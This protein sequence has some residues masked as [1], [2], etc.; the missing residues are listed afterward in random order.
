MGGATST[1]FVCLPR[2]PEVEVEAE[3]AEPEVE[4]ADGADDADDADDEADV[5]GA[6]AETSVEPS[7]A[8]DVGADV[9]SAGAGLELLRRLAGRL[10]AGFGAL[11]M[12]RLDLISTFDD[13]LHVRSKPTI[14]VDARRERYTRRVWSFRSLDEWLARIDRGEVRR[15][16]LRPGD[17]LRA[18]VASSPMSCAFVLSAGEYVLDEPLSVGNRSVALL[19]VDAQQTRIAGSSFGAVIVARRG[20]GRFAARGITFEHR[21]IQGADAVRLRAGRFL[22]ESCRFTGGVYEYEP[23]RHRSGWPGGAGL[24]VDLWASGHVRDCTFEGNDNGLSIE[25]RVDLERCVVRHNSNQGVIYSARV[26]SRPPR[27]FNLAWR[28]GS[29]RISGCTIHDNGSHGLNLGEGTEVEV[30]GCQVQRNT[31]GGLMGSPFSVLRV[32]D[33]DLSGNGR[34]DAYLP[35]GADIRMERTK[36]RVDW[37]EVPHHRIS[38][39]RL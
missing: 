20:S 5:E 2:K 26:V 35:I 14:G 24:H 16:D 23:G 8:A 38:L 6:V 12:A 28:G 31:W 7:S 37:F 33:C 13:S 9:V 15:T 18:A 22:L 27:S 39:P 17:D 10:F 29:G 3:A 32:T 25:H 11:G 34:H 19:G 21:G 36:G 1:F 30:S 4:A